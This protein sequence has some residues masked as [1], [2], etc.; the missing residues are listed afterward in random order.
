MSVL[1]DEESSA[2]VVRRFE[3]GVLQST[4]RSATS[5][6]RGRL[7][8][9]HRDLGKWEEWS[10]ADDQSAEPPDAAELMTTLTLYGVE[11]PP[12][13]RRV[14]AGCIEAMRYVRDRINP[15]RAATELDAESLS[16]VAS[17]FSSARRMQGLLEGTGSPEDAD[18]RDLLEEWGPT[19]VVCLHT[20]GSRWPGFKTWNASP[21]SAAKDNATPEYRDSTPWTE[22]KNARRC[23]LIDR[24][25]QESISPAEVAELEELQY[26]LRRHLDVV[27]PIAMDGARR[28]HAALLRAERGE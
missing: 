14:S 25:I 1:L 13:I 10:S 27:A 8:D 23:L 4:I 6:L 2:Q 15:Q 3:R 16:Y 28:L 7:G 26:A 21:E 12:P 22:E 18:L 9:S 11:L 17:F 19:F 5:Q 20:L 24:Q